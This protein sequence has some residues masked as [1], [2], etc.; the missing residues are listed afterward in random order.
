MRNETFLKIYL[1]R[2]KINDK[3]NSIYF[4]LKFSQNVFLNLKPLRFF[5]SLVSKSKIA[6]L[7]STYEAEISADSNT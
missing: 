2:L 5:Y 6:S 7:A 4:E 3:I 1:L